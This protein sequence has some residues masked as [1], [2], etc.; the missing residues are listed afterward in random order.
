[1][2]KFEQA[3]KW[4][5]QINSVHKMSCQRPGHMGQKLGI[6]RPF[7]AEGEDCNVFDGWRS[8]QRRS[9]GILRD[10]H[11]GYK[12]LSSSAFLAA[13]LSPTPTPLQDGPALVDEKDTPH[14]LSTWQCGGLPPLSLLLISQDDP[15]YCALGCVEKRHFALRGWDEWEGEEAGMEAHTFRH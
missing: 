6:C 12:E 5:A 13:S 15:H 4:P 3:N 11:Q 10:T 2:H 1:M 7:K 9:R 8:E 14:C